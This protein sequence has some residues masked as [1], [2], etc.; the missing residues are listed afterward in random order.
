LNTTSSNSFPS[1]SG[2]RG[3]WSASD[4]SLSDSDPISNWLDT[5]GNA[6]H[7]TQAA[8]GSA[9]P[10][11]RTNQINS[12]P[13]IQFNGNGWFN[14]DAG[15]FTGMTGGNIFVVIKA[16]SDPGGAN[17]GLWQMPRGTDNTAYPY[18]DGFIYDD[19]MGPRSSYNPT[20]S[21]AAWRTYSVIS[22]ASEW[23]AKLD[24]S[25]IYQTL[26]GLSVRTAGTVTLGRNWG[27]INFN[28]YMAEVIL[29]DHKLS[30]GDS[31]L[32][33]AYILSKYGI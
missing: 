5:S 32:I 27:S 30:S 12:Q 11:Y 28:G 6:F 2:L 14:G 13:A 1:V 18:S 9:K 21:L 23:T 20:P 10:L 8:A 19:F 33:Q 3:H 4:L 7:F 22:T 29:Y 25:Q 17:Y 26:T 15:L 16:G 31:A 24:F